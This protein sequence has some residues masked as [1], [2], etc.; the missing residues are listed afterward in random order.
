MKKKLD[1]FVVDADKLLAT[2]ETLS[3][4]GSFDD[5]NGDPL[6]GINDEAWERYK[7]ILRCFVAAKDAGDWN[8]LDIRYNRSPSPTA[9]YAAVTLKMRGACGF[10]PT[11]KTALAMAAAAADDIA[12][13]MDGN[14]TW[15]SFVVGNIWKEWSENDDDE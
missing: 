11:A 13:T 15:L 10:T 8:V 2:T 7:T 12:A 5:D 4:N 1:Q 6:V 9:D 3:H 14:T